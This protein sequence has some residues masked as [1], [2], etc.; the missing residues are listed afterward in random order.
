MHISHNVCVYNDQYPK[1]SNLRIRD[2]LSI[3]GNFW[4]VTLGRFWRGWQKAATQ[5]FLLCAPL[6]YTPN[7]QVMPPTYGIWI[8]NS[9][10]AYP[11]LN[12]DHIRPSIDT[13][14]R[15]DPLINKYWPQNNT[16]TRPACIQTTYQTPPVYRLQARSLLYTN[17]TT[18]NT[19]LRP[20]PAYYYWPPLY[21]P[22][23]RPHFIQTPAHTPFIQ[24]TS[25]TPFTQSLD[26]TSFTQTPDHPFIQTPDHTPFIHTPD[27][28]PFI[29]TPDHTHFIR[30]LGHTPYIQTPDYPFIQTPNRT[31]PYTDPRPEAPYT[32]S[33]PELCKY[34]Q[35]YLFVVPFA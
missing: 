13:E 22:Q 12:T 35:P 10:L 23:T 26:L 6:V 31:L 29:Q 21:R 33:R 28:T 27:H 17:Q 14:P 18:L 2:P 11:R 8:K 32:D 3:L 25:Q 9:T 24:T 7:P 15:P 4:D 20:E 5:S 19:A 16:N 34:E 1:K 30:I